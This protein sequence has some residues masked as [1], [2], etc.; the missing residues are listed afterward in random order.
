M[1]QPKKT[2]KPA[3]E[4]KD[5]HMTVWMTDDQADQITRAAKAEDEDKPSSWVR[6]VALRAARAILGEE[7]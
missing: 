2:R 6:K 3:A 5:A 4:K 1:A 7:K